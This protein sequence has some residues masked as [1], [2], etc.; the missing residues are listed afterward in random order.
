MIISQWLTAS[1]VRIPTD[2]PRCTMYGSTKIRSWSCTAQYHTALQYD[3]RHNTSRLYTTLHYTTLPYTTLH[4]IA[5]YCLHDLLTTQYH[6]I[7]RFTSYTVS[8]NRHEVLRSGIGAVCAPPPETQT[9]QGDSP[10]FSTQ[11]FSSLSLS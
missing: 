1:R 2:L 7:P 8:Y 10:L 4:Y 6:T 3:I 11:F 5:L 9:R